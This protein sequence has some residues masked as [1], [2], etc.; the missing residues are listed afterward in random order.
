MSG[1]FMLRRP[2]VAIVLLSALAPLLRR[3]VL[4]AIAPLTAPVLAQVEQPRGHAA[5][6]YVRRPSDV[7]QA[8]GGLCAS[9]IYCT[10]DAESHRCVMSLH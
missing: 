8:G 2:P 5:R 3:L 1:T 7:Q 6:A 4:I 10:M 9:P